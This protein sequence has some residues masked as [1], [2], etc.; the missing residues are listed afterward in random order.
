MSDH[1]GVEPVSSAPRYMTLAE[2]LR[3]RRAEAE[4]YR[5]LATLRTDVPIKEELD[6]L[7]WDGPTADLEPLCRE[8]GFE[9]FL[10]RMW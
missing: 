1:S 7:R 4:L 3:A 9:R 8:I 6:D 2:T 5:R 10:S